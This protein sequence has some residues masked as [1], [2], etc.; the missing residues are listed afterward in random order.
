MF[1]G[2]ASSAISTF[3]QAPKHSQEE[4]ILSDGP[5]VDATHTLT[6]LDTLILLD[7]RELNEICLGDI[8]EKNMVSNKT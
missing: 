6:C 5:E 4:E 7:R 8:A 2:Q 1:T 3:I